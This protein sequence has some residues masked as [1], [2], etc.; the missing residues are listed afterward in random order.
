MRFK[1]A[2]AMAWISIALLFLGCGCT[3]EA[4][5]Y[6]G[7]EVS[8]PLFVIGTGCVF[9]AAFLA[10]LAFQW[11][12]RSWPIRSRRREWI[13]FLIGA[14]ISAIGGFGAAAFISF[15]LLSH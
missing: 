14:V 8:I 4:L 11:G 3:V 7:K 9:I 2:R 6:W 12:Y 5:F 15:Y 1:L 10:L 13:S